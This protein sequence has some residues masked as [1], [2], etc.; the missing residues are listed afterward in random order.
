MTDRKIPPS[1]HIINNFDF[2]EPEVSY[3]DNGI[4]VYQF[5][6]GKQEIVKIDFI[7]DAGSWQQRYPLTARYTSRM[8]SEGTQNYSAFEIAE[9]F[10]SLGVALSNFALK[11]S[12][13]VSVSM[14]N[15]HFEKILPLID[16]IIN[17]PVFPHKELEIQKYYGKQTFIDD[18]KKV[19]ELATLHFG[20][21]LFGDVHPYGKMISEDDFDKVESAQLIE[22]HSQHFIPEKCKI[23]VSGKFSDD[24]LMRLNEVFGKLTVKNFKSIDKNG[25]EINP[26]ES[27]ILIKLPD[28]L[29]SALQVGKISIGKKHEDYNKL[30]IAN[31]LLGGYFGSRLMKNIREDKGYTYG[32]YS[33]IVT[34]RH[35][36]M[37]YI[38]SEVDAK[39]S[40]KALDEIYL[41]LKKLRTEKVSD[42]EL[43][44]VKKYLIGQILR[45]FDGPFSTAER[46]KNLL[47]YEIDYKEYYKKLIK[48]IHE[49][50]ADDI[51]EMMQ[52]YL[53][54]DSMMELIVGR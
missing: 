43:D 34:F 49:T 39:M 42:S 50:N 1:L 7:F 45:A 12:S 35:A 20:N 36:A 16:E 28:A 2:P 29:Q 17:K 3:L 5:N 14:L 41:E 22:F 4:P 54:E 9:K 10:D 53:H 6:Y 48:T 25:I 15:K 37:F 46:F 19:N 30:T 18:C 24:V 8:L 32:I 23:L 27:R 38:S 40:W 51:M 13:L 21:Q 33:A 11:D 26:K 31:T 47:E 44:L 52:Q